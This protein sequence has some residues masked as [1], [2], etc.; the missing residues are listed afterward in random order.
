MD[1]SK[2]NIQSL[3]M[4]VLNWSIVLTCLFL[5]VP[6]IFHIKSKRPSEIKGI[7]LQAITMEIIGLVYFLVY[8]YILVLLIVLIFL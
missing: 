1:F 8:F 5:K 4:D 3:T 2:I 6:Q 7:S